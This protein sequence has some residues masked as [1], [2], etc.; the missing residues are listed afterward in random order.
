MGVWL[1]EKHRMGRDNIQKM[2]Y[3]VLDYLVYCVGLSDVYDVVVSV[4]M[5]A[6]SDVMRYVVVKR[7]SRYHWIT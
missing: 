4:V 3:D 2:C 6:S 7:S 5:L 1:A